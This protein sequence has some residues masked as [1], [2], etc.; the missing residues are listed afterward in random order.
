MPTH[1]D[2]PP[3]IAPTLLGLTNGDEFWLR[4]ASDDDLLGTVVAAEGDAPGVHFNTPGHYRIQFTA[5]ETAFE[6]IMS[7]REDE[8]DRPSAQSLDFRLVQGHDWSIPI[9]VAIEAIGTR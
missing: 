9:S 3:D 6:L 5:A 1:E 8:G 4:L 7:Y 2:P